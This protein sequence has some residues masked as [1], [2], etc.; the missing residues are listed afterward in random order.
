MRRS[1]RLLAGAVALV[2]LLTILLVLAA[3]IGSL[4]RTGGSYRLAGLDGPVAIGRDRFGVPHI[5]ASSERD[6]YRAL[7]FV[8][9]QDRLW[10]ME[11]QRRVGQ[12]RLAELVGPAAL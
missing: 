9:A 1:L 2:L 3:G 11:F 8:Q 10:Q 6:A 5:Q 7:G 12:G 4:P